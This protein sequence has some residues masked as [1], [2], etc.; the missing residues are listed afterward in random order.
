MYVFVL[1]VA[2][3]LIHNSEENMKFRS[4]YDQYTRLM[5]KPSPDNHPYVVVDVNQQEESFGQ[6]EPPHTTVNYRRCWTID[7]IWYNEKYLRPI[8][9]WKIPSESELRQ[10]EG[11]PG[12]LTV[13][14]AEDSSGRLPA[15][16]RGNHN[17]IPN[18]I[19]GSDH[20]PIMAEF[21]FLFT[22]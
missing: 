8:R 16:R 20:V 7:Y 9:I 17:G 6:F 19:Q 21:Q 4:A 22:K 15:G 1:V 13:M 3:I 11:P 2:Y 12:W 18:S 5:D 14:M 10:E